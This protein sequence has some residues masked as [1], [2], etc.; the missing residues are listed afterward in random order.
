MAK[1]QKRQQP[2]VRRRERLDDGPNLFSVKHPLPGFLQL[3]LLTLLICH[4]GPLAHEVLQQVAMTHFSDPY[5]VL[6]ARVLTYWRDNG[7]ALD[8]VQVLWFCIEAK[9]EY[10]DQFSDVHTTLHDVYRLWEK[11]QDEKF[12]YLSQVL[13]NLNDYLNNSL[14]QG[15]ACHAKRLLDEGDVEAAKRILRG[16]TYG[17]DEASE[18]NHE[19]TR[20]T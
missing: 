13:V 2:R 10:L 16:I 7:K 3:Q 20:T 11:W 15:A 9:E 14:V 6:A 19:A 17:Q 12:A 18:T 5:F 1:K 8:E 4:S